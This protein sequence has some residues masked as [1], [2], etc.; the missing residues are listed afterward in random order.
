MELI[1]FLID[2]FYLSLPLL[3]VIILLFISSSKKGGLKISSQK[4]ILLSNQDESL[5]IDLRDSESFNAGHI[6][7]SINI[8]LVDLSRRI[9]E[10]NDNEKSIILVCETGGS[11][12]NAGETLKKEGF[13]DIF[14]LR[15]GI[16]QWKM[17]NLPLSRYHALSSSST[18]YFDPI[19]K[20]VQ[21]RFSFH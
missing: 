21:H 9:N 15:G 7:A 1:N 20:F 19:L 17:D 12:P 6:T 16:N 10:I 4:L 5:I 14:I 11:S 2:R 8:P 18:K 13:K 3:V